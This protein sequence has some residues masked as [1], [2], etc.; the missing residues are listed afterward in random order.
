MA[1]PRLGKVAS[2]LLRDDG[3][4]LRRKAFRE[5]TPQSGFAGQLPLSREAFLSRCDSFSLFFF[6]QIARYAHNHP[7]GTAVPNSSAARLAR[8]LQLDGNGGNNL[9]STYIAH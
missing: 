1:F 2:R 3:R 4:G 7:F 9:K 8:G 5:R 6:G